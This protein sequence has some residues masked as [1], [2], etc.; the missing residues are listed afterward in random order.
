MKETGCPL[1]VRAMIA[2]GL[3]ERGRHRGE[4]L[5]QRAVVVAVDLDDLP[6]ERGQLVGQRLQVVG[7]RDPGALLQAGCGR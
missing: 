4:G 5:G 6:A 3:P 7:G 1:L 2:V